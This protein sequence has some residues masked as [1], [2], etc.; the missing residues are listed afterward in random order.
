[1]IKSYLL[2]LPLFFLLV[3]IEIV[4]VGYTLLLSLQTPAPSQQILTA[5]N[6]ARIV[7]DPVLVTSIFASLSYA[8][9]STALTFFLGMVFAFMLFRI[10]KGRSLFESV[11]LVPLAISP[12]AV[13]VAWSP[14][15]VWD[16]INTFVHFVLGAPYIDLTQGYIFLPIMVLSEAWEWTPV[17]M[18]VMLSVIM[19]IPKE[20]F[21]AASV[22]GAGD[23]QV[24][25][26]IIVPSILRSKVTQFLLVLRFIDAMRAFEIPFSWSAWVG[27]PTAGGLTDSLSLYLFKLLL[28]PINGA[29]LQY[30]SALALSLCVVTLVST[31]ILLRLVRRTGGSQP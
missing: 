25:K 19:S 13:G 23:L 6:Y 5:A 15:G 11:M 27:S 18:L 22:Y 1:M 3:G 21:E 30:V 31:S 12:I 10:K 26:R 16:D 8:G 24:L 28:F 14:S 4:P 20:V 17:V 7:S 29:S 2:V 9:G